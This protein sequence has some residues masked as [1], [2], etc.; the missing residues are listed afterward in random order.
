MAVKDLKATDF[1]ALQWEAGKLAES[2]D[3]LASEEKVG[4]RRA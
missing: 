1:P 2:L 4:Q 3:Q